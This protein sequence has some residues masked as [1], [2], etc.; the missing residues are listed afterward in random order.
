V[1]VD[2]GAPGNQSY[3][4]SNTGK[5]QYFGGTSA[6][7]PWVSSAIALLYSI[8]CPELTEQRFTHSGKLARQI[9]TY[10]LDG[11]VKQTDLSSFFKS[12]GRLHIGSSS[13]M[14]I[15]NQSD[16]SIETQITNNDF[17]LIRAFP[18][19]FNEQI[20]LIIDSPEDIEISL[21]LLNLQQ[22]VFYQ[23]KIYVQKGLHYN[24]LEGIRELNQGLYILTLNTLSSSIRQ[25]V[26]KVDDK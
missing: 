5:Y 3:T 7:A 2:I 10:I 19:P 25:L 23:N 26:L 17:S 11:A 13:S 20:N 22:Q 21:S 16:C 15:N 14:A 4:I 18:N 24:K 6:A 1:N 12:S 8:P 9:K